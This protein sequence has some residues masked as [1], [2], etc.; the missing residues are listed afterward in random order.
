MI[1]LEA[2]RILNIAAFIA[3]LILMINVTFITCMEALATW[4]V[5]PQIVTLED[6]III[7]QLMSIQVHSSLKH[8][9]IQYFQSNEVFFLFQT[10]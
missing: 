9:P 6:Q 1:P 2:P 7:L 5:F 10:M 4:E 8:F 3:I